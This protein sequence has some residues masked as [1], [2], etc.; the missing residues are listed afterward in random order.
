M[1]LKLSKLLEQFMID[2]GQRM[3]RKTGSI[4]KIFNLLA[5]PSINVHFR[6]KKSITF[7]VTITISLFDSE[8]YLPLNKASS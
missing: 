2:T 1:T 8:V 5:N 6:N 7:F 3:I 4:G